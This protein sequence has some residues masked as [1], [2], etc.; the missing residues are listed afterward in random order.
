MS[1]PSTD[2]H[3]NVQIVRRQAENRLKH[4]MK[5]NCGEALRGP[6]GRDGEMEVKAYRRAGLT[7]NAKALSQASQKVGCYE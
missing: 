5:Q 2:L 1:P 3:G 7:I 6:A 4:R